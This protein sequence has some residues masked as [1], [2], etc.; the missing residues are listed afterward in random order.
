[1]VQYEGED[2]N[3]RGTWNN[4]IC[5]EFNQTEQPDFRGRQE[6]GHVED[7]EEESQMIDEIENLVSIMVSRKIN[8]ENHIGILLRE[9][10]ASDA[11][12]FH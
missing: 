1:L 3:R 4:R 10:N 11:I 6:A 8:E 5:V 7:Q 9:R 12:A 2:W